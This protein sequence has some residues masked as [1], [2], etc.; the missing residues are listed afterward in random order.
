MQSGKATND[1]AT[2][3]PSPERL[4]IRYFLLL[5]PLFFAI[6][7]GLGYPA[8]KRYDPRATQGLSDT[9]KY[10]AMVTGAD[11]S[12]SKE[13]FRCRVLVPYVARPFYWFAQTY[14]HPV[15]PVF[16]ALL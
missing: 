10:Y 14:L 4:T 6:C 12:N 11:D 16:F 2:G 9:Y 7:L 3:P 8:L 1:A 13:L 15:N 5:W